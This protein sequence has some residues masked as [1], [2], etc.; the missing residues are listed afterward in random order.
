MRMRSFVMGAVLVAAT[1][2]VFAPAVSADTCCA[3]HAVDF[4]PRSADPGDTVTVDGIVC[5]AADNSGPLE[6]NLLSYWLATTNVAARPDP[7][8]TPAGPIGPQT[9][10]LPPVGQWR[11]FESVS[12][13]GARAAGS[14]TIVVPRLRS[15]TYQLWWLCDNGGGPGSGIHYSGGPRLAVGLPDS[16][17]VPSLLPAVPAPAPTPAMPIAILAGAIAGIATLRRL[18]RR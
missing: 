2:L 4:Q 10:D 13:A 16:S 12:S 5:L 7:D 14:A 11:P 9:G 1:M 8:T 6:L 18:G 3:N 17:V 15:G